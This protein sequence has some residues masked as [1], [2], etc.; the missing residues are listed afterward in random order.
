MMNKVDGSFPVSAEQMKFIVEEIEKNFPDKIREYRLLLDPEF[1]TR[2]K[3]KTLFLTIKDK[4]ADRML[5][6]DIMD[7]LFGISIKKFIK[8]IKKHFKQLENYD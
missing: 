5:Q 3:T 6:Y 1:K 4:G 2:N 8:K 7:E